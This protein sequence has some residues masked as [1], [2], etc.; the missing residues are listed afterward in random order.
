MDV[1]SL[2]DEEDGEYNAKPKYKTTE[3]R[4]EYHWKRKCVDYLLS[5]PSESFRKIYPED[6]HSVGNKSSPQTDSPT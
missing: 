6:Q 4:P 5:L 3:G 2:G 1:G